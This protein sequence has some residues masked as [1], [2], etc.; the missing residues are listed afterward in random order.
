MLVYNAEERLQQVAAAPFPLPHVGP[1]PDPA[2]A[3][4]R[5]LKQNPPFPFA[6]PLTLPGL[7]LSESAAGPIKAVET[8]LEQKTENGRVW[9]QNAAFFAFLGL[10][11]VVGL[12]GLLTAAQPA[13]AGEVK[14]VKALKPT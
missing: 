9:L 4:K 14:R 1:G 5:G 6:G 3:L 10:L 7:S 13:V 8:W 12:I 2:D 11:F